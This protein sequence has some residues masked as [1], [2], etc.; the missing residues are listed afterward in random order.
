MVKLFIILDFAIFICTVC[1]LYS[2]YFPSEMGKGDWAK[3][4]CHF[5]SFPPNLGDSHSQ[6]PKNSEAKELH[7]GKPK[8]NWPP[9]RSAS[10]SNSSG[11]WKGHL[12]IKIVDLSYHLGLR[13][14]CFWSQS[15][16]ASSLCLVLYCWQLP[17]DKKGTCIGLLLLVR[18]YN[19]EY[20]QT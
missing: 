10:F 12:V 20:I 4:S 1:P 11:S 19:L 14:K 3:V 16:P 7:S 17:T 18:H 6:P 2:F 13:L 9:K 5:G 15:C 8:N